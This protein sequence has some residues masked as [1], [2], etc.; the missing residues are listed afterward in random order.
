MKRSGKNKKKKITDL[1]VLKV[2]PVNYGHEIQASD[3]SQ[4]F[5]QAF[6]KYHVD[7]WKE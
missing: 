2:R 1:V 4:L 7:Q 5:I 3:S 6:T